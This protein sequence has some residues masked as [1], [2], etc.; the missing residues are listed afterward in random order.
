[1]F[2]RPSLS[3]I[4]S[5]SS[6]GS[7]STEQM[8]G[9]EDKGGSVR[10]EVLDVTPPGAKAS[11]APLNEIWNCDKMDVLENKSGTLGWRCGWCGKWF[12][13]VN[14]TKALAHVLCI[15]K[16]SVSACRRRI[17]PEYLQRYIDLH[18]FKQSRKSTKLKRDNEYALQVSEEG[19][20]VADN[21]ASAYGGKRGPR[22][23]TP[24]EGMAAG[25]P[26]GEF[27]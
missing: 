23:F 2:G 19:N 22:R 26:A 8:G 15:P 9:K 24:S 10:G 5:M 4:S 16:Q 13:S 17:D 21:Y 25:S 11:L 18:E 7:G 20:R 3:S 12:T 14:A 27:S 1:M 6:E